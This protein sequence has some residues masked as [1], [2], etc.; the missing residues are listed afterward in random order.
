MDFSSV[1]NAATDIRIKYIAAFQPTLTRTTLTHY[2]DGNALSGLPVN[3]PYGPIVGSSI[4]CVR[5]N[6]HLGK[7]TRAGFLELQASRIPMLEVA[8][9]QSLGVALRLVAGCG[10]C[11]TFAVN[12]T[13]FLDK[14]KMN[15]LLISTTNGVTTIPSIPGSLVLPPLRATYVSTL[16]IG[17]G[18]A[19][20]QATPANRKLE[21]LPPQA[22]TVQGRRTKSIKRRLKN[23][24]R[25][26]AFRKHQTKMARRRAMR[27]F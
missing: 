9:P 22:Y 18:A 16:N 23:G 17:A 26:K 21:D 2:T 19:N 11:S 14:S 13:F 10:C 12:K 3:N 5:V 20:P 27:N 1:A 24:R 8:V 7:G 4:R 25:G 15:P 6:R